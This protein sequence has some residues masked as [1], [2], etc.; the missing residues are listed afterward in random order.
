[1]KVNVKRILSLSVVLSFL[2]VGVAFAAQAAGAAAA[3]P[4]PAIS[5][6]SGLWAGILNGFLSGLVAIFYGYAKNRDPKTG[7]MESFDIAYAWPT[8]IVGGL[9]GV[10]AHFLKMTPQDLGSA[11]TTSPIYGAVTFA[12][13]AVLKAVFRHSVPWIRDAA[14]LFKAAPAVNPT[15]SPEVKPPTQ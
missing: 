7:E 3:A 6:G 12:A 15:A 4:A 1:V 13:E 5:M 11:L 14:A 2:L 9:M 10:I 8:L